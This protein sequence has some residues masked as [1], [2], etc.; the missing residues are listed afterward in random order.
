MLKERTHTEQFV[1]GKLREAGM[2]I[3]N[4]EFEPTV[5]RIAAQLDSL[6]ESVTLTP[7]QIVDWAEKRIDPK[8]ACL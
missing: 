2:K 8:G 3:S 4:P 6:V 7:E 1:Y 5:A